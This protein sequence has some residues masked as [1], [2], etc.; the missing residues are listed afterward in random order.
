V[1]WW[2]SAFAAV[3]TARISAPAASYLLNNPLLQ[4]FHTRKKRLIDLSNGYFLCKSFYSDKYS[5]FYVNP[6]STK[7]SFIV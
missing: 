2:C 4:I 7:T 6:K 3:H 1:C 5:S